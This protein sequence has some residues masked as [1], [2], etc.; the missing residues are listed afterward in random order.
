MNDLEHWHNG[1]Q[2]LKEEPLN[3]AK[4]KNI[5]VNVILCVCVRVCVPWR[6]HLQG[7]LMDNISQNTPKQ[8]MTA[9]WPHHAIYGPHA[10]S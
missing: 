10:P 5:C 3:Q 7:H 9:P 2:K 8:G 4:H 6:K 1:I